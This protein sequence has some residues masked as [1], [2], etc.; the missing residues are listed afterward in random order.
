V[1]ETFVGKTVT[2]FNARHSEINIVGYWRESRGSKP[3]LPLPD[4]RI[5]KGDTLLL[6]GLHDALEEFL[7]G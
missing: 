2:E 6:M 3:V 5:E 7:A 4:D 1:A